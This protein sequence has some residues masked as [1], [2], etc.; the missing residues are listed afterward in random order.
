MKK[1]R[2]FIGVLLLQLCLTFG[3]GNIVV[4]GHTNDRAPDGL[5]IWGHDYSGMSRTELLELLQRRVP[6]ALFYQDQEY[7]LNLD[8]SYEEI[9]EWLDEKFPGPSGF[10]FTDAL[11][12]LLRPFKVSIPRDFGLDKDEIFAQLQPL[13]EKINRPM[14]PATIQF[15]EG[16][17]L[18]TDGQIGKKLDLDRTWQR[19]IDQSGEKK[20]ELVVNDIPSLPSKEDMAKVN[21]ILG[22]Y[23]T[24]FDP[25][26]EARTSNLRLAAETIDNYLI[27]PDE[28]FSFN[29]VVGERTAETGYR[30]AYVFVDNELV[31]DDGG[32]IC[33]DSSTLYQAVRMA[34]LSIL[35]RH[36]HS[37]PVAYVLNGQDATVAYG[38]LDFRFRNDTRGYLLISARTG[39]NWLRVQLFG[40]ADEAHPVPYEPSGY[41]VYPAGWYIDPF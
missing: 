37:M 2:L 27:G 36:S 35:E 39:P 30:P 34:R 16:R 1:S 41:P 6:Q 14:I 17:L 31:I 28:S 3:I 18:R 12:N 13:E 20:I 32:G 29:D 10:W 8:V 5:V 11:Q 9:E 33:Q 38:L 40:L 4:Y 7:P 26:D 23:T 21:Y 15:A 22:D 19:I 24:Y 25:W